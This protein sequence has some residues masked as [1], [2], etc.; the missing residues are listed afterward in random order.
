MN[1]IPKINLLPWRDL[2][3]IRKNGQ[4]RR[5]FILAGLLSMGVVG[6]VTIYENKRLNHQK[7]INNDIK[8]RIGVLDADIA[9]IVALENEQQTLLNKVAVIHGLHNNRIILIQFFEHLARMSE[10]LV[11]YEHVSLSGELLTLTGVSKNPNNVSQFS[12][13]ISTEMQNMLD[14]VMVV[15][16]KDA[17]NSTVS[18]VIS[19]KLTS[20]FKHATDTLTDDSIK[21]SEFMAEDA[22]EGVP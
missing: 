19:A 18:F 16:L 11:Y 3:R 12:Q 5:A 20:G 6:G 4:F 2:H 21:V 9:K 7:N 1:N 17:P 13:K 8:N 15:G 14:D 22:Q 10:G